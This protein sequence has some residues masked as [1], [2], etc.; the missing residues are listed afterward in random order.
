VNVYEKMKRFIKSGGAKK[1]FGGFDAK[2]VSA[3]TSSLKMIYV[4]SYIYFNSIH[5]LNFD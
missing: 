1:N 3:V 4:G 5:N 2:E